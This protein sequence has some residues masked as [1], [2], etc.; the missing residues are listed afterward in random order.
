MIAGGCYHPNAWGLTPRWDGL[1]RTNESD[2]CTAGFL[3]GA[4][5]LDRPRPLPHCKLAEGSSGIKNDLNFFLFWLPVS[6]S[7]WL[8]IEWSLEDTEA[9]EVGEWFIL[10]SKQTQK[11][12]QK[13]LVSHQLFVRLYLDAHLQRKPFCLGLELYGI[14]GTLPT[15]RGKGKG[16]FLCMLT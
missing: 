13:P 14:H 10:F 11:S 16:S 7:N 4:M 5:A 8:S 6:A 15:S 2:S 1:T 3:S 9:E 12:W